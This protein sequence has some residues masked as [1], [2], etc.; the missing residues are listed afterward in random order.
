MTL[1]SRSSV[2]RFLSTLGLSMLAL[3]AST[4][5]E[6]QWPHAVPPYQAG[7]PVAFEADDASVWASSTVVAQLD[8]STPELEIVVGTL[9]GKVMA[10]RDDGTK[11][12]EF[13]TGGMGISAKAA[14]A[15]LDQDGL[16]E[17]VIGAGSTLTPG[18]AGV[19]WILNHDGSPHCSFTPA[20]TNS[21]LQP[22]GVYAT[23]AL[24]DLTGDGNLEIVV[25]GWDFYLRVLRHNCSE[26][27]SVFMSD[28]VWS[29]PAIGDLDGDGELDI[30]IGS[31]T[32]DVPA[33]HFGGRIHAFTR[34]GAPL[35]GFPVD[36]DD[37][38]WSSP[39]LADLDGDG[40]LDVVVGMGHC[41][42]NPA[43]APGPTHPVNEAVFAVDRF[44]QPL[45]GW[46]V[47]TP[48]EYAFASPAVADLDGDG[49]LEVV[50]NTISKS[51][52]S[53]GRV[54]VLNGDGTHRNGWPK[55]PVIPLTCSTTRTVQ[56]EASPV[57]ADLNSD[58]MLEVLLVS[59]WEIVIWD[60]AGNQL[61]R[62]GGCPDPPGSWVVQTN[63]SLNSSP[64]VADID[65][66][67]D[68]EVVIGGAILGG[69]QGAIYVWDFPGSAGPGPR[70]DWPAARR[71]ARNSGLQPSD[72]L[73]ADGFESGGVGHWSNAVP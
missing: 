61:S 58:G 10:Y 73:F 14:V 16:P 11:Y 47:P 19:L 12:W 70:K 20:D 52:T 53:Q 26:L 23:A 1:E 67:G 63:N 13:D 38:V 49:Q 27:W 65:G 46:P 3:A 17:V 44:G 41:W 66:D 28:T 35:A 4:P 57:L 22:D 2:L 9:N 21:D 55:Q 25:A 18:E 15:D 45:P 48:G 59:N 71:D 50:V 29:S 40:F 34:H 37:V 30:V 64:S 72:V 5:A 32:N 43:C 54:L 8:P 7:F 56:T 62:D 6:A 24:A 39:A 68:L 42:D 33:Q 36:I 51:P 60:H 69:A 31:D